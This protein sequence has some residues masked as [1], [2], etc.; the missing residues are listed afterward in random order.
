MC[1][2]I[3]YEKMYEGERTLAVYIFLP[4]ILLF[5][6]L[7]LN[8]FVAIIMSTYLRLRES[9]QADTE[10]LASLLTEEANHVKQ[11]W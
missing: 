10:A 1:G 5:F 2:E 11:K 4:F 6:M 8:M 7:L 3:D 9:K